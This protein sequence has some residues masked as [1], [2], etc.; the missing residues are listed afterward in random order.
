MKKTLS[1]P[2]VNNKLDGGSCPRG[3][4]RV[5]NPMVAWNVL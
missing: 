3:I 2:W 4:W 5:L 1:S